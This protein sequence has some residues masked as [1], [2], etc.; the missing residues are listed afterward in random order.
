MCWP[1]RNWP[2]LPLHACP[3]THPTARAFAA[4]VA[5]HAARLDELGRVVEHAVHAFGDALVA[6]W[7]AGAAG[8]DA[9]ARGQH[10]HGHG[11][12]VVQRLNV[13][14]GQ[15][16]RGCVLARRGGGRG[17]QHKRPVRVVCL[18]V[19]GVCVCV[20][21]CC[22]CASGCRAGSKMRP[23]QQRLFK[24]TH[25]TPQLPVHAFRPL[26]PKNS[27]G[28]VGRRSRHAPASVSPARSLTRPCQPPGPLLTS[29][30]PQ[31][32]PWCT[33]APGTPASCRSWRRLQVLPQS[34]LRL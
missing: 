18:C 5:T 2:T 21:A 34:R 24:H 33:S 28:G 25:R 19:R 30:S 7:A 11:R 4:S 29:T 1:E 12:D 22:A 15:L 8:Q 16:R 6:S 3:A 26:P 31:S 9:G 13:G 14:L 10:G 17:R 32:P 23:A 27:V 20:C